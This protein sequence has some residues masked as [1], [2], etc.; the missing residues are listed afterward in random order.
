MMSGIPTQGHRLPHGAEG[1]RS[2]PQRPMDH[3]DGARDVG[4]PLIQVAAGQHRQAS[5]GAIDGQGDQRRNESSHRLRLDAGSRRVRS[6]MHGAAAL[7][8]QADADPDRHL[9]PD[10]DYRPHP[11]QPVPHCRLPLKLAPT[12]V[13]SF[14]FQPMRAQFRRRLKTAAGARS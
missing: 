2:I 12:G 7:E 8:R 14:V 3:N 5:R 9:E 4:V 1:A 13:I 11:V 10:P 6:G